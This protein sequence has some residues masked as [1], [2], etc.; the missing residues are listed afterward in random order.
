MLINNIYLMG[1]H[2]SFL[3]HLLYVCFFLLI[4]FS[5]ST[6]SISNKFGRK[7]LKWKKVSFDI[8][9]SS[10]PKLLGQ[11]QQTWHKASFCEG[12]SC[13]YIW[14]A[15]SF[16]KGRHW[17]QWKIFFWLTRQISTNFGTKHS[18]VKGRQISLNEGPHLF[19]RADN[20]VLL[21]N[22]LA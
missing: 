4:F 21:I 16:S 13:L 1:L 15:T 7:H 17:G 2:V 22:L 3:I 6:W 18:W 9:K 20:S 19:S 10:V 8:Q 14:G 11:F 5:R 12:N